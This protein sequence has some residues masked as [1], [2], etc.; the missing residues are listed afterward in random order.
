MTSQSVDDILN[1]LPISTTLGTAGQPTAEQFG[2]IRAAGYQA[3]VNLAMAD[4]TSALPN[5][6]ELVIEQG[7][8][9]VHIPV[10]WERPTKQDLAKFF[11][12]MEQ[13]QGARIFVHCVMNMRVSVFV[14]LYRVLQ[15]GQRLDTARWAVDKIW[16]PNEV[17]QQFMEDTLAA[18]GIRV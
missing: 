1:Y 15:L 13:Y 5:E 4:S 3:V 12:V 18:H 16:T 9:Y 14:L 6:R 11:D 17:W 2:A 7:M 10:V 8:A